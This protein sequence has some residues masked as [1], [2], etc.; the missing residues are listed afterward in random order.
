MDDVSE[1]YV[2]IFL[3]HSCCDNMKIKFINMDILKTEML[4]NKNEITPLSNGSYWQKEVSVLSRHCIKM[5]L[6]VSA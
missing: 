3:K 4:K 6:I 2:V 5:R 1:I